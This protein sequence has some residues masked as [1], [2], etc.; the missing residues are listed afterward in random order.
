MPG[1]ANR[2]MTA[3]VGVGVALLV[4]GLAFDLALTQP[5]IQ[6]LRRLDG[7][8]QELMRQLSERAAVAKNGKDLLE[9]AT[10]ENLGAGLL[11]TPRED[12]LTYVG[13]LIERAGLRQLELSG[14]GGQTAGGTV[15]SALALRVEGSYR[16][17]VALVQALEQG[18][19]LATITDVDI[20]PS[21]DGTTLEARISLLIHDPQPEKEP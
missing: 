14:G 17:V 5:R 16:R 2:R 11:S 6:Q 12:P 19:R 9:F 18:A 20:E 15:R 1:G 21:S 7:Q 3:F 13:G 10:A 4:L 8:R